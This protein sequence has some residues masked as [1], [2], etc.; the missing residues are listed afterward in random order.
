MSEPAAAVTGGRGTLRQRA[1]VAALDALAAGLVRLP[2]GLVGAAADAVGELWYRVT[3]GRAAMARANLGRV[4]ASLAVT[5]GGTPRARRAADPRELERLVRAAFRHAART[6]A[7]QL[8]RPALER[9]LWGRLTIE[10]PRE[11]E[12]AMAAGPS[13]FAT[14]HFGSIQAI[15]EVLSRLSPTPVTAPMET[16]DDPALQAFMARTRVSSGLR[17]VSLREARRE[18]KAALRRGEMVGLVADRDVSGGGIMVPLFG[19]P[20]PVPAGPAM[21][22]I[23]CGVPIRVAAVRRVAGERY[24]GSLVT[25][26]PAVVG[27]GAASRRERVEAVLRAEAG[28]F[29]HFIAGAPEQWWAVFFPIWPDLGPAPRAARR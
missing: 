22:A 16:L 17:L 25:V 19:A 23:E 14:M 28:A 6:Y 5:G 4:C 18:L 15:G 29:E 1:R 20:A 12:A 7:E 2:D 9:S 3:P 27:A 8:R 26:D 11:V 21:L 13:V 10:N 24:A